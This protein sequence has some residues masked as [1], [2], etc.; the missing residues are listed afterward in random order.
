MG[1]PVPHQLS[2]NLGGTHIPWFVAVPPSL[3][4]AVIYVVPL[5]LNIFFRAL[6]FLTPSVKNV[7]GDIV[8]RGESRGRGRAGWIREQWRL[9]Q[10]TRGSMAIQVTLGHYLPGSLSGDQEKQ[11]E[12]TR[13]SK[14]TE[15]QE[16]L[17]GRER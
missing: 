7:F 16:Q 13:T 1:E 2:H 15:D 4:A 10:R 11:Q 14:T 8:A 5:V 6:T 9:I 17:P 3:E 12:R